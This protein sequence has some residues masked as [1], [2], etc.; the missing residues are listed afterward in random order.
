M[1]SPLSCPQPFNQIYANQSQSRLLHL[2][3]G[4]PLCSLQNS[5]SQHVCGGSLIAKDV[6][7][8]VVHCEMGDF[9]SVVLGRHNLSDSDGE[10]ITVKKLLPHPK[11][12]SNG[13]T[14]ENDFMHVFLEGTPIADN[15]IQVKLNS[16]PLVPSLVQDMTVMGWGDTDPRHDNILTVDEF[17][18]PSEV[19]LTI[20][21][22]AFSPTRNAEPCGMVDY[23][24]FWFW[25]HDTTD[26]MLC[27]K[28]SNG[29]GACNGDSGGPMI[30]KGADGATDMQ[31]GAVL[32]GSD[33]G[34]TDTDIPDIYAH[35]TYAY[36]WIKRGTQGQH[37]HVQ[38]WVRLQ[39]LYLFP[40][41]T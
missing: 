40:W 30:I 23:S 29:Q 5:D 12:S 10:E 6:V 35:V 3:L 27:A 18:M 8:T 41:M 11:N 32:F 17:S 22:R 36:D 28:S 15:V 7:L 14:A 39:Q 26:S 9:D 34:C 33:S 13:S 20:D 21:V 37:I 25:G 31:V 19:L 38:G 16:D 4:I 24:L 1:K 2:L